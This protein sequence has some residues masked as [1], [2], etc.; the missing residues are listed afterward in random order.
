[1]SEG[2]VFR[3]DTAERLIH[4]VIMVLIPAFIISGLPIFNID[5]FGWMLVSP[6]SLDFF[7]DIH[8]V[9]AGLYA[10]VG[11]F[12]LLYYTVAL[13]RRPRIFMT[14]K[15]FGDAITTIKYYF[16]LSKKLPKIGFHHPTEVLLSFWLMSVW[17]MVFM[18]VSGIILLNP[19]FFPVW[20]PEWALLI[21]D[22]FFILIIAIFLMHLYMG[23]LF[24]ENRPLYDGMF[25]DGTI[26][27]EYAKKYHT[28]WYEELKKK[29]E[30]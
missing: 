8:K 28:L 5:W 4:F 2:R 27:V 10:L 30:I 19:S 17:F 21:H 15:D 29:G 25:R 9:A 13:R 18:G 22:V 24:K 23:I 14:G 7:R 1:M 26:P 16:G 3:W 20:V 11:L 6:L 12:A